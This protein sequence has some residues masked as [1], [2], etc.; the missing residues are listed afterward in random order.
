[1]TNSRDK[2][3][4]RRPNLWRLFLSIR[5]TLSLLTVDVLAS[6]LL[7]VMVKDRGFPVLMLPAFVF[8][9]HN[10]PNEFPGDQACDCPRRVLGIFDPTLDSKCNGAARV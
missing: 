7:A 1:L 9:F 5:E 10:P 3:N 8:E 6:E 4:T 2:S